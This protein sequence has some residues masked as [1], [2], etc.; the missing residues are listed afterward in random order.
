M[1]QLMEHTRARFSLMAKHTGT[2]EACFDFTE[3]GLDGGRL[4][5]DLVDEGKLDGSDS[6]AQLMEQPMAPLTSKA[7]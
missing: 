3:D 2:S 6:E 4:E 7:L 5:S 1:V